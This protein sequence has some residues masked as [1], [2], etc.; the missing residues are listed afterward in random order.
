LVENTGLQSDV[1][2]ETSIGSDWEIR[3]MKKLPS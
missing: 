3:A 2:L 1:Q